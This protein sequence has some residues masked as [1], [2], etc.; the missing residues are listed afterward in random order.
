MR[1]ICILLPIVAACT[2]TIT[3]EAPTAPPTHAATDPWEE[4]E[5]EQREGP[6]RYASRV[7]GCPKVRYATLGNLLSSRG[8]NLASTTPLSAGVLYRDGAG[9]LAA[10][11]YA[12]LERETLEA[13]VST[14][15]K[16][17]DIFAMA[18]PEIIANLPQRA[19]CQ[20]NGTGVRLFDDSGRCVADGISCLIGTPATP[21]HVEICNQTVAR[22]VD[23]DAG[24]RLAVAVLAAAAF[25]CE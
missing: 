16:L 12:T 9:A 15:S 24:Q 23:R 22:A 1:R 5:R 11:N 21:Q 7:H 17:F 25:T 14:T 10:P 3:G 2:G 20:R 18:A 4:L 6:P 19:A 13:G 8:V